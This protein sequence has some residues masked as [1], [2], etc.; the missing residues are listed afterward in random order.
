MTPSNAFPRDAFFLIA[1][2]CV[3][4]DDA[5]NLRV[6]EHLARVAERIPG[7]VIFKASFDKANRS[8]HGAARG[9]G[10]DEG[11][12]ALDRVRQASGLPILTDVHHPEQC[13]A[14]AQVADVLQIPAFLC[15]QTDLLVAAGA[16]GRPVNVKKGQWMHPEGMRGAVDK[17]RS[18]IG[19]RESGIDGPPGTK[20]ASRPIPDSR[21][22]I[23]D[24]AV[25]ERGTFLGYGDLVVDMRSF[26]RMRDACDSAVIFDATHSVQRPGRGEGGASGGAREFI[27]PLTL[28]A[29]AAGAD[30]LFIETHPHPDR[31]PSDGPNMLPLD[32]LD[33]L[34]ERSLAVWGAR[35]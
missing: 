25:T 23:P 1:G 8:N 5:L 13:S 28:G 32:E 7:G 9:P 10:L 24:V 35:Q 11:L 2:P 6:A 18:G 16:T 4:E 27:P 26:V 12:A 3:I 20:G 14:A 34:L 15:R 21:F 31:A 17:V 33:T 30:G 29:I 19:H 22:P